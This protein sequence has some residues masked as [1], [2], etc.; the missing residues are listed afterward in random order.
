MNH[1]YPFVVSEW[2]WLKLQLRLVS[3]ESRGELWLTTF[4][5][6]EEKQANS[7]TINHKIICRI[8]NGSINE[9]LEEVNTKEQLQEEYLNGWVELVKERI[10]KIL[11]EL[12]KLQENLDLGVDARFEIRKDN[13]ISSY[14]ICSKVGDVF[15]WNP[16]FRLPNESSIAQ[17]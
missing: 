1:N 5:F 14:L 7:E 8:Y 2:D 12:P 3:L 4:S 9:I 16:N 11:R 17:S 10:E 13:I 6:D 15:L